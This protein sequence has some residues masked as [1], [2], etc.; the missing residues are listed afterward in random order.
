MAEVIFKATIKQVYDKSLI[1]YEKHSKKNQ[2]GEWET[3]GYTDFKVWIPEGQ[4][5]QVFTE[6]DYIEVQGR[7]KT[8]VV[9]KDGKTYKNLV[10]NAEAIEIIRSA[11]GDPIETVKSVVDTSWVDKLANDSEMPF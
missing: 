1:V 10:V 2:A 3:T 8:E 9:E 5:G 6:K 7:Q 4:R 11:T